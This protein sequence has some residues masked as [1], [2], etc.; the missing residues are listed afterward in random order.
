MNETGVIPQSTALAEAS[1]ASLA[2]L[3]SIDP[4]REIAR[5]KAAVPRIVEALRAQRKRFAKSEEAKPG[6]ATPAAKVPK[7]AKVIL[8]QTIQVQG[9]LDF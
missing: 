7:T 8:G 5:F 3:M 9:D 6:K 1:P 4:D 2:D